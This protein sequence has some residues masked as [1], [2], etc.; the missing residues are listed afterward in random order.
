MDEI[1][2]VRRIRREKL[3][4]LAEQGINPYPHRYEPNAQAGQLLEQ[5]SAI[6]VGEHVEGKLFRLAGRMMSKRGHGKTSFGHLADRS[7]QIQ[8]YARKDVLGEEVFSQYLDLDVGDIIGVEGELFRTNKGEIT[9]RVASFTLLSKSLRPLPEKWHGLTNL[10]TRYRQRYADLI[11]N[12]DVREV[13]RKRVA[14]I[15]EMRRFLDERGFMEVETPILQ[16]IAGGAAARPFITHH[17]A[18]SMDLYLRV[19]P[20]LYLKR[21]IVGGFERVYEIN[22]NFRNEGMDLNHNPEFTLLEIYQAYTNYEGVM[23]LCEDL[24]RAVA[25]KVC[26]CLSFETDKGKIEL[27]PAFTRLSIDEAIKKYTGKSWDDPSLQERVQEKIDGQISKD[28]LK[29]LV[30]EELVEDKLIQPTFITDYPSSLCPLSK[31]KADDPDTAERFELYFDGQEIAN[32]YSELNNPILQQEHFE[33][34][35]RQATPKD[36]YTPEVDLDYVRALEY[37]MPP[38]GGLGIGIDRLVMLLS[39]QNSIREVILFPHMRPETR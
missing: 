4:K 17:N 21:L 5:Y 11:V 2:E 27:E 18:L 34:Q 35:I 16:S 28:K 29:M 36:E 32:A 13:F 22:R 24:I 30:F 38:T 3:A 26:G 31:A 37:G 20:E 1:N 8:F 9:I 7:G 25:F 19:S 12:A 39:G 6:D 10:E 14:T 23:E 33:N 15:K